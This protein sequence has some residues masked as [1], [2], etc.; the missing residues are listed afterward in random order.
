GRARFVAEAKPLV[1]QITAPALGAMLRN[2]LAE[3]ARL[4]AEEIGVLVPHTAPAR[5][6]APPPRT[7]RKGV[8][9]PETRLL[10]LVLHRLDLAS[11][12]DELGLKA[13]GPVIAA[14]S[15]LRGFCHTHPRMSA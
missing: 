1:A 14:L 2:R 11:L 9:R 3:L 5:Q 6:V 12:V 15:S 13:A 7:V 10:G 4:S 8:A